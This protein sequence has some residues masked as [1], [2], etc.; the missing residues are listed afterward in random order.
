VTG[1][2]APAERPARV[3]RTAPD[4]T[5]F[6][7][8]PDAHRP[9]TPVPV[10]LVIGGR[11]LHARLAGMTREL[12]AAV[13]GRLT[14]YLPEYGTL[15]P[16]ALH[17]DLAHVVEQ[18]IRMFAEAARTG[19]L[20]GAEP[21]AR[22]REVAARRAEEGLP[23]DAVVSAYHVGAEV[24]LA[25]VLA[26]AGPGDLPAVI[27]TQ[28]L[29]LG[30]LQRMTGAASAGYFQERQAAF[31]D[32]YT[33][34]QSLLSALLDGVPAA[35]AAERAGL[36]LPP[37]YLVLSLAVGPHPDELAPRVDT[38]VAARRKLRRLRVELE[39]HVRNGGVRGGAAD[40][41]DAPPPPRGLA[42]LS[43]L[44]ALSA[45]GGVVLLPYPVAADRLGERDWA[46][47]AGVLDHMARVSGAEISAGAAGCAPDG[48]AAAV[49]LAAEVRQ[50]AAAFGRGPGLHRL[51][52]VLLEYQLTRPSPARDELASLLGPLTSRPELLETV[53]EYVACGLDRHRAAARLQVHPNT[54][55]YRLRKVASLT[56][57][58]ASAA[59]DLPRVSAALAAL[60]A[61][62]A[63]RVPAERGEDAER[64]A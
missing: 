48:V 20:P 57:L 60:D 11:P 47:L 34:R 37:C 13:V 10:P 41:G 19:R 5:A 3:V 32:E 6:L 26:Y 15:P 44:S 14:A 64:P 16:E 62:A 50:V 7:P 59:A 39:R 30:Y 31:G 38:A 21:L 28:R 8:A 45:D 55:N 25:E 49:R 36:R 18:N 17:D 43:P 1:E 35:P 63:E 61:C 2:R 24:C 29:L 9:G 27:A 58:D 42:V 12:T 53:R 51:S 46:W 22:M 40:G 4:A 52:D 33:A 54:V 23:L 56:G